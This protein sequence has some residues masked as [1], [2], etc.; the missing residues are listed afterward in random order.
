MFNFSQTTI[1]SIVC[2]LLPCL[3]YFILKRRENSKS[4]WLFVLLFIL[5]LWQIYDLTGVGG[6]TDI[7]CAQKGGIEQPIIR[8][9]INLVPFANIER[10]FYLNILLLIPFGFLVPLIWKNYRKAYK[11]IILGAGF[12]LLIE[13]SQLITN[14][15][16]DVD[17][18]IT[19]TLGALIGFIIW[20]LFFKKNLKKT[21][22]SKCDVICY[23]LLSFL[24]MFFLYYPFWF[25]KNIAPII[26]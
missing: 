22:N 20:K 9:R 17:D 18:L 11:I 4:Y 10:T 1:Y 23:I 13:L 2:A 16:T 15:T 7:I 19:N 26:L 8:A 24:G 6:L 12:S 25:S 3:I 5:Y 21:E 14:R